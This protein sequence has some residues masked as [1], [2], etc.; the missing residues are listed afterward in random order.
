MKD[1]KKYFIGIVVPVFNRKENICLLLQHLEKQTETLFELIV[2]DD[3]STDNVAEHVISLQKKDFWV[4]K[5]RY[6]KTNI[7]K[8]GKRSLARN[9]GSLNLSP[10]ATHVLFLDSDIIVNPKAIENYYRLLKNGFSESVIFGRV[11]WLPPLPKESYAQSYPILN[12]LIHIHKKKPQ[13]IEGTFVGQEIRNV[14]EILFPQHTTE[15]GVRIVDGKSALFTNTLIP[16]STLL[17]FGG[18]DENMHGYGYEDMEFGIRLERGSILSIYSNSVGGLHVWHT[19]SNDYYI[20]NQFNLSY[21]LK[22]HGYNKYFLQF[23]DWSCLC[24][25]HDENQCKLF[26]DSQGK[27]WIANLLFQQMI[28]IKQEEFDKLSIKFEKIKHLKTSLFKINRKV[29]FF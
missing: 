27:F 20:E 17:H 5:L 15:S 13:R 24:H 6:I 10:K 19:K 26:N 25:Y 18:F 23:I 4:N 14:A 7:H 12:K 1:K 22:K 11:D 2:A 8:G 16:L 9:L 28:Q 21:L 29:G 3:G